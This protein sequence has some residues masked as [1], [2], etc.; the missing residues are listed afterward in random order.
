M[1][2]IH[3]W[4]LI[5]MINMNNVWES[6]RQLTTIDNIASQQACKSTGEQLIA[7]LRT[8]Q[9]GYFCTEK[10]VYPALPIRESK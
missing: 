7:G 9:P 4:I 8:A 2:P 5:V 6:P 1:E 10:L 3:V